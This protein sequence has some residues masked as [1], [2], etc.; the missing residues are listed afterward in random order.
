[1]SEYYEIMSKRIN[2]FKKILLQITGMEFTLLQ[3]NNNERKRI[4]PDQYIVKQGDEG[5][6]AFLILSGSLGV[7]IDGK[8]VEMENGEIFGELFDSCENRK[9]SIKAISPSEIIEINKTALEAILLSSNIELHKMIQ[10]MSK[11]LGKSS[12]Q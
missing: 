1:M 12:D 9:A 5:D 11:E 8:K 3:V 2:E 6:T 7:E 4:L 10:Q